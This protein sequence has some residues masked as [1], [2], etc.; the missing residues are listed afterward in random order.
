M[1]SFI[2]SWGGGGLGQGKL[3]KLGALLLTRYPLVGRSV[4]AAW[5]DQSNGFVLING[6]LRCLVWY[7][8]FTYLHY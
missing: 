5:N 4:V 6:I 8:V 3:K 7:Y 1:V 2:S